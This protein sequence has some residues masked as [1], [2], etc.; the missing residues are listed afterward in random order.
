LATGEAK[1]S[2]SASPSSG[3]ARPRRRM[4]SLRSSSRPAGVGLPVGPMLYPAM[5]W[6][7]AEVPEEEY[8]VS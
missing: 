1:V 2:A 3:E 4:S 7:T 8:P 5:V 6:M